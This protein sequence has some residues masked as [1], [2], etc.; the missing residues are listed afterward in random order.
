MENNSSRNVLDED[1]LLIESNDDDCLVKD[2]NDL[3]I[4]QPD[5]II[6]IYRE[7]SLH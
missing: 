2:G 7:S 5:R 4:F 1:E 3:Y 6:V